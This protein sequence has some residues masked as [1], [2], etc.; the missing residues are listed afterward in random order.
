MMTTVTQAIALKARDE[1]WVDYL[2]NAIFYEGPLP[3]FYG[4]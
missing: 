2:E 3:P 1:Q 4:E